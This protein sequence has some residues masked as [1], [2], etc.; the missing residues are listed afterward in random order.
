MTAIRA[1]FGSTPEAEG[2]V[3]VD[4][5]GN[6][7]DLLMMSYSVLGLRFT[8]TS[9]QYSG[10]NPLTGDD[11]KVFTA[12]ITPPFQGSD[13]G[14]GI[15][16]TRAEVETR[17]GSAY[18]SEMDAEG[19]TLEKYNAG[20]KKLGVVYVDDTACVERAAL[21]FVNLIDL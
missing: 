21:F 12:V 10:G 14:I 5:G 15:G 16:A 6:S 2:E 13:N 8:G 19:R 1:A 4:V 17:F 11:R 20:G 9:S 7:V 3:T 18:A